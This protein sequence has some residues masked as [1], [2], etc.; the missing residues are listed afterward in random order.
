MDKQIWLLDT[1]IKLALALKKM[2]DNDLLHLDIKL[3][4][5]FFLNKYTPMLADFGLT[6]TLAETYNFEYIRGTPIYIAPEIY[7][8]T[9]AYSKKTDIYALGAT[10]YLMITNYY[11]FDQVFYSGIIGKFLKLESVTGCKA[12]KFNCFLLPTLTKM[13]EKTPRNRYSIDEVIEELI[14]KMA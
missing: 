6:M 2:H 4:N 12:S 11:Q 7:S 8:V 14:T 1:M 5:I 9:P 3:N 10:F 13:L